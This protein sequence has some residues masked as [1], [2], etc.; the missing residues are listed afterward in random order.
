MKMAPVERE[1][2][3]CSAALGE[4]RHKQPP[5]GQLME[6]VNDVDFLIDMAIREGLVCMLFRKLQK[7]GALD[8][9]SHWQRQRLQSLYYQTIVHNLQLIQDLKEILYALDK[10][11][12][13]V[14]LLQGISLLH[15]VY[16]DVGL[17]PMTD[18]DLWVQK[19]DYS[20]FICILDKCGYQRDPLYP[21][22]F[23]KGGTTLDLH[24]HILGADRIKTRRL[25]LAKG[26]E[27]I[28]R[29]TRVIEFEGERARSLGQYD[30]VLYLGL[31]ALKHNVERLM[32]LADIENLVVH[33]KGSHWKAL[34]DRTK[35]LGQE[36][37]ILYVGFLLVHLL[38]FHPPEE[39]QEVLAK[40]KLHALE[41]WVLRQRITKDALPVWGHLLLFSPGKGL[42]RV[43]PY[44]FETLFPRPEVMRQIFEHT[45]GL[46]VWQLY[47]MRLIQ[48]L[49]KIRMALRG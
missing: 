22:T 4:D 10:K 35:E 16:D 42:H 5:L 6:R 18:I 36:R 40:N 24:T 23:R 25:L 20:H 30:Q 13:D 2:L 31:H 9:L 38:G 37:S 17:R 8:A 47:G 34:L 7:S 33:W 44:I 26:Q 21:H 11:G 41:K 45:P 46:D 43:I 19:K 32:W 14:V 28:Y 15:R 1:I 12:I 39:V 48:L 27:C 3:A 29:Q 49:S